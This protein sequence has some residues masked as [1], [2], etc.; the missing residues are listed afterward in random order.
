MLAVSSIHLEL[1][2]DMRLRN[3]TW[4]RA[5]LKPWLTHHVVIFLDQ[6][7]NYSPNRRGGR[8]YLLQ[9]FSVSSNPSNKRPALAPARVS[10]RCG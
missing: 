10:S 7:A 2:A 9:P 8:P 6:S 1:R 4:I 3:T 5:A